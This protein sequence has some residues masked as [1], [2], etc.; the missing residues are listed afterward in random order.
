[1]LIFSVPNHLHT[2]AINQINNMISCIHVYACRLIMVHNHSTAAAM[3]HIIT[4][5]LPMI[6]RENN[7]THCNV[8]LTWYTC[9]HVYMQE[10]YQCRALWKWWWWTWLQWQ[11][12]LYSY[13]THIAPKSTYIHTYIQKLPMS[14]SVKVMVMNLAPTDGAII[15]WQNARFWYCAAP[16][17]SVMVPCFV[18]CRP[19]PVQYVHGHCKQKRISVCVFIYI[20]IYI[21]ACWE[22]LDRARVSAHAL[23]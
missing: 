12:T 15:H 23:I 1:M 21:Y 8:P 9:I 20:Y 11:L 4:T 6:Y 10:N 2:A 22:V 17:L 5:S 16:E 14:S 13:I 7:L 19:H 3:N 18:V